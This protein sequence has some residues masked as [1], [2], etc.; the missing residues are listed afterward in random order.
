M[1][2]DSAA[3]PY[4]LEAFQNIYFSLK[5]L[6]MVGFFCTLPFLQLIVLSSDSVA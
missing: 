4:C 6:E 5:S 2:M 3:K 1:V